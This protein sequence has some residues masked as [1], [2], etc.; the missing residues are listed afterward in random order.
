MAPTLIIIPMSFADQKSLVFPPTG[1]SLKWYQNFF[2]NPQWFDS[3]VVSLKLAVIMA[4]V[5]MVIGT[6][7]AIGIERMKSRAGV[8]VVGAGY[9]GLRTAYYPDRNTAFAVD[10][11]D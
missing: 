10:R 11:R 3:F 9:T 2:T 1:I 5:A 7:A 6:M 4:I 8:C